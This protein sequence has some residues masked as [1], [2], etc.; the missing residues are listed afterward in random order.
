M[1]KK[2]NEK[3]QEIYLSVVLKIYVFKCMKV[4]AERKVTLVLIEKKRNEAKIG[5]RLLLKERERI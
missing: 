3:V 1:I 5:L 2:R 4:E